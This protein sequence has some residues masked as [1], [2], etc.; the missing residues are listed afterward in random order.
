MVRTSLRA[1]EKLMSGGSS[2]AVI[3]GPIV[4]ALRPWDSVPQFVH[5]VQNQQLPSFHPPRSPIAH[6]FSIFLHREAVRLP[7][8]PTAIVHFEALGETADHRSAI[9]GSVIQQHAAFGHCRGLRSTGVMLSSN[10]HRVQA[11]LRSTR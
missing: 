2:A 9:R 4:G 11:H 1:P 7:Q 6:L 8:H 3:Q 5:A 10:K